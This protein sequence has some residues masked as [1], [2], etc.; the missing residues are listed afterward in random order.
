MMAKSR[1]SLGVSL[2]TRLFRT[3]VFGF[4]LGPWTTI[5]WFLV[6]PSGVKYR[7]H[8]GL[9]LNQT[10]VC[11]SNQLCATIAPAYIAGHHADKRVCG[12]FD[13]YISLL[14]ACRVSTF[15]YQ[16]YWNV[17]IKAL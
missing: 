4:T 2:L 14:V 9:K 15:L 12:W 10:W 6:N 8:L 1:M 7:F 5:L 3:V 13:V 16:R 17:G 11:Y